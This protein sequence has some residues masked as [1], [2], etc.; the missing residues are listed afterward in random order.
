[1]MTKYKEETSTVAGEKLEW[2]RASVIHLYN[3]DTPRIEIQHEKRTVY[4]DGNS[5]ND[6]LWVLNHTMSDAALE[7]PLVDP[8]TFE[9]TETKFTAGQFALMAASIYVFL[10]KQAEQSNAT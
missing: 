4:P 5:R 6:Y 3:E 1:M 8:D 7:I 2:R 10:D 9:Q